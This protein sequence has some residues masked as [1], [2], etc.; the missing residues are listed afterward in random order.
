MNVFTSVFIIWNLLLIIYY[1]GFMNIFV[2]NID[3]TVR[4]SD[5]KAHFESYGEVTSLK[6]ITEKDTGRSK[7]YGFVE[8]PDQEEG[9]NAVS[10]LN[11]KDLK[12]ENL[13]LRFQSR[14]IKS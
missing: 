10:E 12:E 9:L 14:E 5:L 2:A 7:G 4:E 13:L 3:F 1:L 11:G 8:M 6:I